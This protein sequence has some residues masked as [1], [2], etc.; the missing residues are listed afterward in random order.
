MSRDTLT[1]ESLGTIDGGRVKLA[2]EQALQRLQ[3]DCLDR[4][5]LKDARKLNLAVLIVPKMDDEAEEGSALESCDVQFVLTEALPKRR[6]KVYDM[7]VAP[8]G[9]VYNEQAPERA[10]QRTLDEVMGDELAPR[11]IKGAAG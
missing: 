2:W 4:P 7:S 11:P 6:T 5:R 8:G 10:G 1:I 3:Q 9:L